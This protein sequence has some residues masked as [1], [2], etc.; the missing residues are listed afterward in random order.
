MAIWILKVAR[1]PAPK[2]VMRGCDHDG[3][4]P[5]GLCHDFVDV[6]FGRH[7]VPNGALGRAGAPKCEPRLMRHARARPERKFQARLQ[8]KER[9]SPRIS[10]PGRRT[11]SVYG[12]HVTHASLPTRVRRRT[13]PLRPAL[14]PSEHG[15]TSSS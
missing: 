4:R 15:S 5:R 12:V 14:L 8:V 9:D 1:V 3:P 13:K 2:G 7:V 6:A 11:R 10:P